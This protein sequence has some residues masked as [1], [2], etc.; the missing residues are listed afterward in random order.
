M[1]YYIIYE[2]IKNITQCLLYIYSHTSYSITYR[3]GKCFGIITSYIYIEGY[4]ICQVIYYI[5]T[6]QTYIVFLHY[7][8]ML[9]L[10]IYITNLYCIFTIT[11]VCI[12][13]LQYEPILYI[14]DTN[15]CLHCLFTIETY[16][17]IVCL[18][19]KP[20]LYIY[21]TNIR[22]HCLFTI[23]TYIVYLQHKHNM[24]VLFIYNTNLH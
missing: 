24:F 7:K 13:Q 16:V 12:V 8:P 6:I 10:F 11:Y 1:L 5:F 15:L 17:C 21:H 22:L 19:Y 14:Y 23:Q 18:Q 4:V 20:I 9:A 2:N 3:I